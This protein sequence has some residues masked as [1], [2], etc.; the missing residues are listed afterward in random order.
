MKGKYIL[1]AV[2]ILLS[3][4]P[5]TPQAPCDA[6]LEKTKQDAAMSVSFAYGMIVGAF[7]HEDRV[8]YKQHA[9]LL[10]RKADEQS[11]DAPILDIKFIQTLAGVAGM[12][13]ECIKMANP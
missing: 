4:V 10:L 3:R 5:A 2:F 1:A 6:T 7:N 9:C 12:R 13:K 11:K 8:E